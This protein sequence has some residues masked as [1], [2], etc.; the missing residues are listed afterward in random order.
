LFVQRFFS[1]MAAM[2][3]EKGIVFKPLQEMQSLSVA[4]L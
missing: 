2:A 1:G 4:T 3:A